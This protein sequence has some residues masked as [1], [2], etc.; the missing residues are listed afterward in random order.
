[1]EA[2]MIETVVK[3]VLILLIFSALAG[4]STYFERKL[5][6]F[7]QR[8]P[9]PK[10]VGPA[11]LLQIIAD[12]IKMFTKEDI[13]PQNAVKSVFMVG[14]I[15]TAA[16][17]FIAFTAIPVFP[18]FTVFDYTVK[19]IV[20]D[21]NV[22][23]L[24]VLGAMATGMFGFLFGGMASANKWSL[25][26]AA[27]SSIQLLSFEVITGLS[28][29]A[30][31]M[32]VGSLSLIDINNYQNG[33]V[34][35]WLV[36]TQPIAFIL[37]LIAGFAETNRT[38]IDLLEHEAELVAGYATEYSGLR[39]GMF[40]IGEYANLYVVSFLVAIVFFGGFNDMWFIPGGLALLI[41][42][43]FFAFFFNWTRATWPHIRPDQLMWLC[44]KVLMPLAF[45]NI[46]ITGIV[47]MF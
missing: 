28:I 3:I 11:G 37:F 4:F 44:W 10:Y 38:P 25:L 9:G 12:G 30:P 46:V 33:G 8:R 17:A 24:F 43:L 41:K 39:W 14:P 35:D 18:E 7:F 45:L 34:S 16:S 2:W 42:V 15:I 27:R 47:L 23:I 6:S 26:G 36:W 32:L 40:A 21:I 1:M 20:A 13:V 31:L 19:P 22:G 29:L 5:L